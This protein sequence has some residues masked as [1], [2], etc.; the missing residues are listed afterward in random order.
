MKYSQTIYLGINDDI[1]M[2]I[3]KVA[4]A[5]TPEVILVIPQN[6]EIFSSIVNLKLLRREAENLNKHW[7]VASSRRDG[8]CGSG[9]RWRR[10][11][12]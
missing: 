6:A 2:A 10:P 9:G 7:A 4:G 12:R 1:A 5:G 3:D 8:R 11:A